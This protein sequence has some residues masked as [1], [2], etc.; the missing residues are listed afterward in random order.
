MPIL[1]DAELLSLVHPAEPS[2]RCLSRFRAIALFHYPSGTIVGC[3][4]V[5]DDNSIATLR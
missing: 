3:Q 4:A 1:L 5:L 2:D